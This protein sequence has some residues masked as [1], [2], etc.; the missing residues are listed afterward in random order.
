MTAAAL[1]TL[2]SPV[3]RGQQ[4]FRRAPGAV[5]DV[6]FEGRKSGPAPRRSLTGTWEFAKGGAEG[7]QADGVKT[8][9]SD[10]KTLV[11]GAP[12][13]P[14]GETGGATRQ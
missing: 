11:A 5:Y 7:I 9:P 3:M 12:A 1:V 10:G 13:I 4:G 2:L 14:A 6:D 8:M